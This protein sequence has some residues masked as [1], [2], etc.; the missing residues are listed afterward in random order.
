MDEIKL[1][2]IDSTNFWFKN[3]V[4]TIFPFFI[5]SDLLINYGIFYVFDFLLYRIRI[6]LKLSP[7]GLFVIM[8]SMFTG[9]PSGARYISKL[10]KEDLISV[11]EANRIIHFCHFSNPLFIINTIGLNI[12]GNKTIGYFILLSH[13]LSNFIM[14]FIFK[15]NYEYDYKNYIYNQESF[16]KVFSKSIIDALNSLLIILGNIILFQLLLTII[17]NYINIFDILNTTISLILELSSGLISLE[18]LNISL[19]AKSLI[20]V[21]A[22]SF[23]GLCIHSQVYTILSDTKIKYKNY[24][25][26]RIIQAI[27]APIIFLIICFF[28]S[29]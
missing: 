19:I 9:L 2:I 3:L 15:S 6:L 17:F 16:G 13:Y 4:P 14:I 8:F 28:H 26:G 24:L 25:I 18:K 22:I 5:V 1:I 29:V 20:V 27:I 7:S 21:S 11:E 23:G 10:L 12:L